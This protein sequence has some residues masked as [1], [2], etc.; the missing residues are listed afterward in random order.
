[1]S[2]QNQSAMGAL[3]IAAFSAGWESMDPAAV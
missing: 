3:G 2:S 1:M